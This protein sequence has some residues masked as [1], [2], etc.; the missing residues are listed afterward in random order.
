MTANKNI[1]QLWWVGDKSVFGDCSFSI[2]TKGA[3]TQCH[4]KKL[5]FQSRN[6][7]LSW[8]AGIS[9]TEAWDWEG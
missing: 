3:S 4:T 7:N 9:N 1:Y 2:L 6:C 8:A 5:F